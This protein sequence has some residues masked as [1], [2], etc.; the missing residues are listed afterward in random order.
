MNK[1]GFSKRGTQLKPSA[2]TEI[3][4]IAAELK[5][6]G[7]SVISLAVGEPDFL[8]PTH[9]QKA[10]IK[11]IEEGAH[12]YTATGG[13]S[14][15][16]QAII[17]KFKR[18]N[19]LDFTAQEVM[20][21]NGAKQIIY[22]ALLALLNDGDEVICFAPY[23]TSY[24]EMVSLCGGVPVILDTVDAPKM[25]IDP[26]ALNALITPKTKCIILNYPGNPTGVCYDHDNLREIAAVVKAHPNLWVLSDE[27]YEHLIYSGYEFKSF[28]TFDPSI[29]DR[30]VT[31]NGL[32]KSHAMP[33]WRMGYCGATKDLIKIMTSIQSQ[34]SGNPSS[35]TQAAAVKALTE[36]DEE[37]QLCHVRSTFE[38]RINLMLSILEST[39]LKCMKPE[40]AFYLFVNITAYTED[41]Q[42]F[43][44]LL[45]E[46]EKVALVPGAAFGS[47]GYVRLS[48]AD[49][50]TV[51]EDACQRIQN[52]L[53]RY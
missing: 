32:S 41:D 2:T 38:K 31:I 7:E 10:G 24:P 52:F 5:A 28:S 21:A 33:G 53:K 51:L 12:H 49:S 18:D 23:W 3:S 9:I 30:I 47:P 22:N 36:T 6:Q 20:A 42:E 11:A 26:K 13:T 40:G 4:A 44:K 35:I 39:Q 37:S 15:L 34:S 16:K 29:R 17:H 19:G 43:C 25:R 1:R 46:Q 45:L 50:E 48:C 8:T 27:I 14:A